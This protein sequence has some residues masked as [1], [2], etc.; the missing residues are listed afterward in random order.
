MFLSWSGNF[1]I[2]HNKREIFSMSHF[3]ENEASIVSQAIAILESKYKRD[4]LHANSPDAVKI[5]CRL[6]IGNLEHE[7]F[8]VLFLDYRYRLISAER[9][10][11]GSIA[12]VNVYPR[13][14][15]K[16]VLNHNASAVII[17]HNHPS[18]SCA[19]SEA[20]KEI[21]SRLQEA[22]GLLDIRVLDHIIVSQID[23]FSFAQ[24]GIL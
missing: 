4:E 8:H 19:P 23:S 5:Y 10:F 13:E 17:L 12:G 24:E 20:D 16:R 6:R 22:L 15:A 9:L 2:D 3:S 18:G 21:T 14:I 11:M 1:A 7:E